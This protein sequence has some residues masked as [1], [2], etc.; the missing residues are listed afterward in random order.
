MREFDKTIPPSGKLS[1][2]LL[3]VWIQHDINRS[4]SLEKGEIVDMISQICGKIP[5]PHLARKI[6]KKWEIKD[7]L[8]WEHFQRILPPGGNEKDV[9]DA[10]IE[11]DRESAVREDV[12]QV[13]KRME[14][15]PVSPRGRMTPISTKR[16]PLSRTPPRKKRLPDSKF[17]APAA[18]SKNTLQL[19]LRFDPNRKKVM[20]EEDIVDMIT[21]ILGKKPTS[22][23][24]DRIFKAWQIKNRTLTWADFRRL[25]GSDANESNIYQDL[26][27]IIFGFSS[28]KSRFLKTEAKAAEPPSLTVKI[29]TTDTAGADYSSSVGALLSPRSLKNKLRMSKELRAQ[30]PLEGLRLSEMMS[31]FRFAYR[32]FFPGKVISTKRAD[33]ARKELAAARKQRYSN[34]EFCDWFVKIMED[35]EETS[36]ISS[37]EMGGGEISSSEQ[38]EKRMTGISKKRRPIAKSAQGTGSRHIRKREPVPVVKRRPTSPKD[39]KLLDLSRLVSDYRARDKFNDLDDKKTGRLRITQLTS[40]MKWVHRM[41]QSD[42]NFTHL[43]TMLE[44]KLGDKA[45]TYAEFCNVYQNAVADLESASRYN[46]SHVMQKDA[47]SKNLSV[48]SMKM[49]L[50]YDVNRSKILE[51][52]EMKRC[53]QD[54]LG[55][56]VDRQFMTA[57]FKKW[58]V[59]NRTVTFELWMKHLPGASNEE[60][61]RKFLETMYGYE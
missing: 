4:K 7:K 39:V 40:L 48:N 36:S 44:K 34:S 61:L 31:V 56:Q 45:L 51:E 27:R 13:L 52:K 2:N 25:Y 30:F 43:Q 12:K 38:E 35:Y 19:W 55:R 10:V 54:C 5:S 6:F 57:F 9:Y 46:S 28:V 47:Q 49:W 32:R 23:M 41:T 8:T 21:T 60:T 1:T 37:S 22:H 20:E 26:D 14:S 17:A 11:I 42:L 53:I 3:Q 50:K 58:R 16:E 29:K 15:P 33:I 24:I 59:S 18:I